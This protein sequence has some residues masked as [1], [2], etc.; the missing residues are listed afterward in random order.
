VIAEPPSL[1]GAVHDTTASVSPGVAVTAVGA[2]GAA[3][4]I[5]AAEAP[6]AGDVPAAL[7][8]VTV[9]VYA[10]PLTRPVTVA[11]VAPVVFAGATPGA[12]VTV[13]PVIAEPPLLAGAVHD[14]TAWMFPGVAVT[15]VGAPG[16]ALGMT[17]ALATETE[18]VP[19]ALF[20]VTVNV[21]AVPLDRPATVAVVAMTV[22]V[23]APPGDAVILYPVIAEPPLLAGA[24][25][26]TTA[27]VSA[28]V[29]VTPVGAAGT[30]RGVTAALATD[31]D[32]VPAALFAVTVNV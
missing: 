11:D 15:P 27:A 2:P 19:A 24:V 25:H 12:A 22:V 7:V 5:T 30:V 8:A 21:Y 13:Y 3:L 1:A 6:D 9:N 17:A 14:T 20:A 26:D 23:V 10:V 32:E 28:G 29:A 18:D 4:G 31:A 16:T